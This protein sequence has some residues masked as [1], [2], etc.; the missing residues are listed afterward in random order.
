MVSSSIKLIHFIDNSGDLCGV[1]LNQYISLYVDK[2]V[3]LIASSQKYSSTVY[4][5]S[6]VQT[7]TRSHIVLPLAHSAGMKDLKLKV[8]NRLKY[9]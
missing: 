3:L 2:H 9:L 1:T 8:E 4:A 6:R 7:N 5:H